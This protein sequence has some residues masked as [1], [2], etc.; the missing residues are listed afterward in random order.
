L[1]KTKKGAKMV[2]PNYIVIF[3]TTKYSNRE[4]LTKKAVD[5]IKYF[6]NK[7]QNFLNY[8]NGEYFFP[9]THHKNHTIIFMEEDAE[10]FEK[11]VDICEKY[12]LN[13]IVTVTIPAN[14]IKKNINCKMIMVDNRLGADAIYAF[15]SGM[16]INRKTS[17]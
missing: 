5:V 10:R 16:N 13:L 12:D 9:E 11:V 14:K 3:G 1:N 15:V 8:K 2:N 6:R 7:R 4:K 17:I